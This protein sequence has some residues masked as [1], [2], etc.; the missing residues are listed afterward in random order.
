MKCTNVTTHEGIN[1]LVIEQVCLYNKIG[2]TNYLNVNNVLN[3]VRYA[4][5]HYVYSTSLD[6]QY[7]ITH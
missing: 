2:N 3:T 5:Q 1:L 6:I 4:V 7:I